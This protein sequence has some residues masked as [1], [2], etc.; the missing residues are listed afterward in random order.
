MGHKARPHGG[1]EGA[2][3]E[4]SG[5]KASICSWSAWVDWSV[6]PE[7]PPRIDPPPPPTPEQVPST[8]TQTCGVMGPS[9]R[10]LY[11]VPGRE[12]TGPPPQQ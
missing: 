1:G 7:E 4:G 12:K 8:E 9:E 2:F 5:R 6:G 10:D 11:T 3:G